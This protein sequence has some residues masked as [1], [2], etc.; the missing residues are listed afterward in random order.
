MFGYVVINKQ[1]L[2]FREF[3]V[4]RSY[5]CGLCRELKRAYGAWGQMT[6]SYDLTFLVL[7]LTSLYG[8]EA[9][10]GECRCGAHPFRRQPIRRNRFT[11]YGADMNLLLFYHKCQDD[12]KD[13]QRLS[14]KAFGGLLK[15]K[16][17][18]IKEKYPQKARVIKECLDA[19]Q[20]CEAQRS[21]NLDEASG[22]FGDIMG[23][24]FV[25]RQDEWEGELRRMGFF[26]GKFVYL[27]D[28]YEDV[29]KDAKEGNYNPFG[30]W[31][32]ETQFEDECNRILTM[33]M[34][35]CSRSFE[36]LP[37]I[38]YTEILRNILYSGVWCRYEQIRAKRREEA[39]KGIN[40]V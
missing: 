40:H 25:F 32:Q 39:E 33:M 8:E 38:E 35:E 15:G 22:F 27:M 20:E 5:Y 23:E 13:E 36:R 11:V 7:L 10:E 30:E 2:K 34:A 9:E 19:I 1:E 24:V 16:A 17:E 14:R 4:Y 37:L 29:K 26:L 31:Y 6:L 28:A 18:R 12:W 3:D 21:R